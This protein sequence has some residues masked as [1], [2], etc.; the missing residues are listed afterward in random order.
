MFKKHAITIS[1]ES[2]GFPS[3]FID[4]ETFQFN[5]NLGYLYIGHNDNTEA[6]RWWIPIASADLNFGN[7]F[8]IS[9]E[10]SIPKI[11][12]NGLSVHYMIDENKIVHIMHKGKFTVG[13]GSVSMAEFFEYYR[14]NPGKWQA[15]SFNN[16]DYLEL[17][18]LSLNI[19]D[20]D[21]IGLLDSLAQFA[22][23]I[24]VFKDQYR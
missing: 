13:Y 15:I 19:T 17:G 2:W 10:M 24:P 12:N 18:K 23:F 1:E 9:F 6:N 21:F 16:Y 11:H 22:A 20:A 5:T 8:H 3:G 7:E 4:C 14:N